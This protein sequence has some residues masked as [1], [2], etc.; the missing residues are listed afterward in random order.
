MTSTSPTI[1]AIDFGTSNSLLAA[2]NAHDVLPPVPLDPTASDPTVLRTALYFTRMNEPAYFGVNAI[3]EFVANG[4]RGRLIRSIKRHLPSPS[5]T[6]TRV[7]DQLVT[8]EELIGSFL[9]TMRKT[10][11]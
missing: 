8:L 1:F 4:F 6:K 9:R 10:A 7:G 2:A 3:R 5:F 11:C